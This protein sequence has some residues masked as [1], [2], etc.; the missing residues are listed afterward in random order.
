MA[1]TLGTIKTYGSST[2]YPWTYTTAATVDTT[3]AKALL[4][5]ISNQGS[6]KPNPTVKFDGS[7]GTAMTFLGVMDCDNGKLWAYGLVAPTEKTDATIYVTASANGDPANYTVIPITECH[8]SDPFGDLDFNSG[9]DGATVTNTIITTEDNSI[10]ISGLTAVF[11]PSAGGW[12]VGGSPSPTTINTNATESA[13][14]IRLEK[15]TAG[16][17][18]ATVTIS[19]KTNY[20]VQGLLSIEIKDSGGPPKQELTP[21]SIA[22][23]LAFGDHL[24]KDPKVEVLAPLGI[25]SVASVLGEH[26]LTLQTIAFYNENPDAHTV[27]GVPALTV[28]RTS[29]A[30]VYRVSRASIPVFENQLKYWEV[31]IDNITTASL[32]GIGGGIEA[33]PLDSQLGGYLS[34]AVLWDSTGDARQNNSGMNGRPTYTTGDILMVA[35]DMESGWVFM[36]KNGVWY[37]GITAGTVNFSSGDGR[38]NNTTLPTGTPFYPAVM[39]T[40]I[41]DKLTTNFGKSEFEYTLPAGYE[42]LDTG[43]PPDKELTPNGIGS[44]AGFGD[45]SISNFLQIISPD[46]LSAPAL[47]GA[48][49]VRYIIHPDGLLSSEALGQPRVVHRTLVM[50]ISNPFTLGSPTLVLSAWLIE[51]EGIN[52]GS[53]LFGDHGLNLILKMPGLLTGGT[54]GDPTV[55]PLIQPTGIL[56]VEQVSD[57]TANIVVWNLTLGSIIN[58]S[59]VGNPK[60]YYYITI[61]GI[62]NTSY[63]G[64]HL[65]DYVYDGDGIYPLGIPSQVVFGLH[66]IN[67]TLYATD[68]LGA[69]SHLGDP[70]AEA[71]NE[72]IP[73]GILS[74]VQLGGAQVNLSLNTQ[75]ILNA[76]GMG[77]PKIVQIIH[78]ESVW[79]NS[80]LGLPS[81][82]TTSLDITPDG[83][84]NNVYLGFPRAINQFATI[85]PYIKTGGVW[86]PVDKLMVKYEGQ[87]FELL[88][89]LEK[90]DGS[91]Q[92]VR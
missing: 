86:L 2:G 61:N 21:A 79:L 52:G 47:M 16:S 66:Q 69:V 58:S 24:V 3:G 22:S 26:N 44:T 55:R 60:L 54:M 63:L 67:Q 9:T 32:I 42:S 20:N 40:N 48:P 14:P 5:F 11:G 34:T 35:V 28:E 6:G 15:Q 62:N 8:A 30:T 1:V 36:G 25:A 29:V 70:T 75:G 68:L 88:S 10:V 18:G 85:K 4:V 39:T 87:W 59:A 27:T 76:Y 49:K 89:I 12:T 33:V 82:H 45:H 92:E 19:N 43:G 37:N 53:S 78:M 56:N 7:S 13:V 38:V 83:I 46:G 71:S 80:L 51:P 77:L 41:G 50:G 91:W 64:D 74:G 65:I 72:L 17:S 81:V 23:T 57:P 84:L 90:V 73:E 31:T